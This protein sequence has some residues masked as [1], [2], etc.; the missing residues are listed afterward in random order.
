MEP[1]N[2]DYLEI[3]TSRK[4]TARNIAGISKMEKLNLSHE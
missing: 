4:K 1:Y 3:K 2:R